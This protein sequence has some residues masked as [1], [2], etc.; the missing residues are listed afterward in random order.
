MK[1]QP[2][3]IGQSTQWAGQRLGLVYVLVMVALLLSWPVPRSVQA[4]VGDLDPSFG[5]AGKVITSFPGG[6]SGAN[7][8]A[9][10]SDGRIV[11]GGFAGPYPLVDFTLA[12]YNSDGSLDTTFG[13]GGSVTTDF[14]GDI[15]EINA[16][17]L[18][19]M[20]R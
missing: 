2:T 5:V 20:A 7:A 16:L 12:R 3:R 14:Y 9:I 8:V 11:L 10:Q 19:P 17:A 6:Q 15:D 13:S 1:R 18:S 4:S